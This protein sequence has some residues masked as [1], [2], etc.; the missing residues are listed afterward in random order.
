MIDFEDKK[1]ALVLQEMFDVA[2]TCDLPQLMISQ[3]G[4]MFRVEY[5]PSGD[6]IVTDD[7]L[8]LDR[9]SVFESGNPSTV[10]T[11][12]CSNPDLADLDFGTPPSTRH[13]VQCRPKPAERSLANRSGIIEEMQSRRD[14]VILRYSSDTADSVSVNGTV[15]ATEDLSPTVR[16]QPEAKDKKPVVAERPVPAQRKTVIR[17]SSFES[18]FSPSNPRPGLPVPPPKPNRQRAAMAVLQTQIEDLTARLKCTTE[19]RDAAIARVTELEQ[20]LN[21]YYEKFGCIE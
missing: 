16:E 20:K 15:P 10:L 1:L 6:A 17:S 18:G 7:I 11:A 19:E 4:R 8:G 12:N 3:C 9:N 14:A 2:C 5:T 21:R 13:S